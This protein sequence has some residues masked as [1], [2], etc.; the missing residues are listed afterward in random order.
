MSRSGTEIVNMTV[1]A[2]NVAVVVLAEIVNT[3]F[4]F[5]WAG[6]HCSGFVRFS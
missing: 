6:C 2:A 1:K 5:C 4:V 3:G